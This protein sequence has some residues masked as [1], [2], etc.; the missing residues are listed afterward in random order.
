[1]LKLNMMEKEAPNK[2]EISMLN[3]LRLIQGRKSSQVKIKSFHQAIGPIL[4]IGQIFGLMP[5]QGILGKD[6]DSLK[7]RWISLR[8]IY[9]IFFLT[10]GTIEATMVV[11][12]L[13]RMGLCLNYVGGILFFV[14]SMLRA[15]LLFQMARKW[16][17]IMTFWTQCEYVFLR[18][19][20]KE[21]KGWSLSMRI[22]VIGVFF[23]LM[24]F[25]RFICIFIFI[26]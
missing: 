8:T 25:S 15:V 19:P 24:S 20:Y 23:I 14:S 13:V 18:P 16:K 5:I 21:V 9:S 1:M 7:F 2:S 3:C 11:V 22:R 10:S 12:R 4:V 17:K 26:I 6:I